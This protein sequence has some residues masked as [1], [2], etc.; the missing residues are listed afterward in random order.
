MQVKALKKEAICEHDPET[1]LSSLDQSFEMDRGKVQHCSVV[2]QNLK[3]F[4]EVMNA[5]SSGLK[6]RGTIWLVI[7][8]QFKSL[9]L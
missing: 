8:T 7:S 6:S 4:W 1:L 2:N 9:H 5:E 3:L